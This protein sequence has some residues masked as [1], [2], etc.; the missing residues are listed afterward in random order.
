M[1]ILQIAEN[2]KFRSQVNVRKFKLKI[3]LK[4]KNIVIL[5]CS[6]FSFSPFVLRGDVVGHVGIPTAFV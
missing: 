3:E 6:V 2:G 4:L 1:P 5:I